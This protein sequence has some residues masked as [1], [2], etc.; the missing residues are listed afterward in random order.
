MLSLTIHGPT[1]AVIQH[2]G[3]RIFLGTADAPPGDPYAII[4]GRTSVEDIA[5]LP[6]IIRCHNMI[7][8]K[9]TIVTGDA[10]RL[11][12]LMREDEVCSARVA[13]RVM[14]LSLESYADIVSV[15]GNGEGDHVAQGIYAAPGFAVFVDRCR[16]A[17]GDDA[18]R[19]WIYCWDSNGEHNEAIKKALFKGDKGEF[20]RINRAED[21]LLKDLRERIDAGGK[22]NA[23]NT[24]PV[25]IL[26]RFAWSPYAREPNKNFAHATFTQRR[27]PHNAGDP[28]SAP[29]REAANGQI[30]TEDVIGKEFYL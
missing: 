14:D 23:D 25:A 5:R 27:M 19:T 12:D 11:L 18:L 29:K 9:P 20:E 13:E 26:K 30:Y 17:R 4:L 16:W 2:G 21:A 1:T 6:R 28:G 15:P 7:E 22:L 8:G 24:P 3:R 10:K